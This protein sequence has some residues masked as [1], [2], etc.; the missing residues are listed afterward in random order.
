MAVF[1]G[2]PSG[3]F[4]QNFEI[5]FQEHSVA[6]VIMPWN[7]IS[8]LFK[9]EG[10][11]YET[12]PQGWFANN[13]ILKRNSDMLVSAKR[14][15]LFSQKIRILV[16]QREIRLMPAGFFTRNFNLVEND[17]IVGQISANS[18]FS[19]KF[20]ASLPNDLPLHIQIFILSLV[21]LIWRQ[22][23]AAAATA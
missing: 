10:Y 13:F 14:E 12:T 7:K 17:N 9:L 8:A 18:M 16:D 15:G 5:I 1:Q 3:F 21:L 2:I 20:S 6:R 22:A 19:N 4:T 23:A 11:Q